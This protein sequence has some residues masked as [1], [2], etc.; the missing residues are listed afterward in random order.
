MAVSARGITIAS[1]LLHYERRHHPVHAVL[2]LG[3]REHVAV[4]RPRAGILAIDGD[5]PSL[6]WYMCEPRVVSD[7]IILRESCI[8]SY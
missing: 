5:V 8:E 3:V 4:K 6:E 2:R 7:M 1:L